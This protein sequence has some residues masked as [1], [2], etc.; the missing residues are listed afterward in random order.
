MTCLDRVWDNR[1]FVLRIS[2]AL[3]G[4]AFLNYQRVFMKSKMKF[5][6]AVFHHPILSYLSLCL[7]APTDR[8]QSDSEEMWVQDVCAH[9]KW[10]PSF[11]VAGLI[12]NRT[13][14]PVDG[15]AHEAQNSC[16]RVCVRHHRHTYSLDVYLASV[17]H[18]SSATEN[19]YTVRDHASLPAQGRNR[20]GKIHL[21]KKQSF[22]A[23][24]KNNIKMV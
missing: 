21:K 5:Q 10:Q 22:I 7:W 24:P 13:R 15:T 1:P 8:V 3:R 11:L 19:D 20:W 18:E 17:H 6:S 23:E 12:H 4:C 2:N 16:E 14:L 9:Y